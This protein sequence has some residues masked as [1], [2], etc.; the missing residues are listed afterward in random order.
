MQK[1]IID[2]QKNIISIGPKLEPV[3]SYHIGF[4]VK[5][6]WKC[7]KCNITLIFIEPEFL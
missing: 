6:L 2:G 4:V 3:T 7:Y 5:L 1:V